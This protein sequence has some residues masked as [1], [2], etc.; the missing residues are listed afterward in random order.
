[1]I[2]KVKV[3]AKKTQKNTKNA[4]AAKQPQTTASVNARKRQHKNE[5]GRERVKSSRAQRL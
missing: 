2:V 4:R 5:G 1:L 3:R